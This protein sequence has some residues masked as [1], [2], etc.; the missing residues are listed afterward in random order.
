MMITSAL[1]AGWSPTLPDIEDMHPRDFATFI[2]WM[3]ERA[4][5]RRRAAG[6]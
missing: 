1:A 6:G 4:A 3:E 5:D 2:D